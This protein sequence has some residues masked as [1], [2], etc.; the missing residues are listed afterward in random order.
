M[1]SLT[2]VSG[3]RACAFEYRAAS[4]SN[5]SHVVCFDAAGEFARYDISARAT[6]GSQYAV[7]PDG[8]IWLVGSQADLLTQRLPA[9]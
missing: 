7:A 4:G 2:A 3:N 6:E 1:S 8:S 9:E 5:P